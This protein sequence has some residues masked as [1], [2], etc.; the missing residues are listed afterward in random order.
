MSTTSPDRILREL[1]R[2]WTTLAEEGGVRGEGVL[3]SCTMTLLVLADE[4]D[5]PSPIW[6]TLAA[7]MPQHPSRAILVRFRAGGTGDT[8]ARVFAQ[9]WLPTGRGRRICC[10]QIE[11]T[12]SDAGLPDLPAL[13]LPLAAPDLPVLLW[14]RSPR[15]FQAPELRLL[16][17]GA[18]KIIVDTAAL[19]SAPGSLQALLE[20]RNEL[21]VA[22]LAWT[23]LTRWRALVSQAFDDPG[24]RE[25]LSA[26]SEVRVSYTGDAP[27]PEAFYMAAWLLDGVRRAGGDAHHTFEAAAGV[28]PGVRSVAL[29]G[30]GLDVAVGL[31]TRGCADVRAGDAAQRTAI[32]RLPEHALLA[33]EVRI[34][35]RDPVF[36]RILPSAARLGVSSAS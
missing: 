30:D 3:R 16:A 12:A 5:D 15:I 22:D 1:A 27:P 33:E 24:N 18:R 11:I 32:A 7:L 25:R 9:C 8:Q 13:V 28:P 36:D 26:A 34:P 29:R 19:G 23:R 10:E 2:V 4:T 17:E 20:R 35:G 21:P 6:E 14:C 31:S